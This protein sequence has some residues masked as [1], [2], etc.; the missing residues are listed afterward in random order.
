VG[1]VGVVA[2]TAVTG[3]A[4][5]LYFVVLCRRTERPEVLAPERR[6]W[7]LAAVAAGVTVAG[8]LAIVETDIHGFLALPLAGA[9]RRGGAG[10]LERVS[11]TNA[12]RQTLPPELGC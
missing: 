10:S 1:L 3:V 9:D 4:A 8:E 12:G 2:V 7:G 6:W 11:P 5:S